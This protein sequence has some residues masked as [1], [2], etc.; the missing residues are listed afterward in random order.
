MSEG[1]RLSVIVVG[2]LLEANWNASGDYIFS[3]AKGEPKAKGKP[4]DTVRGILQLHNVKMCSSILPWTK[5]K[6]YWLTARFHG[7]KNPP[8]LYLAT[9][10]KDGRVL[11]YDQGKK[12]VKKE[13][14]VPGMLSCLQAHP[15]GSHVVVGTV[16]GEVYIF[17]TDSGDIITK[18]S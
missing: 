2:V 16:E 1:C 11:V 14:K 10:G 4:K 13:L 9:M 5:N 6:K 17:C 18:T 3:L 12:S 8:Y 7:A 15:G